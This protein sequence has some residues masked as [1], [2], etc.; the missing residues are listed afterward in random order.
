MFLGTCPSPLECVLS[1]SLFVPSE[2]S[3]GFLLSD[4]STNIVKQRFCAELYC[5]CDFGY[6][7]YVVGSHGFTCFVSHEAATTDGIKTVGTATNVISQR[8]Y[9]NS[10]NLPSHRRLGT[11]VDSSVP[12]DIASLLNC[13]QNYSLLT[14]LLTG[15]FRLEI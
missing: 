10:P 4:V 6:L 11:Q 1:T 2:F 3:G 9:P 13:L 7:E 8:P 12:Q 5:V 14:K 15:M